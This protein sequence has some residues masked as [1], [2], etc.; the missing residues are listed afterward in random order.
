MARFRFVDEEP[1]TTNEMPKEAPKRQES[2]SK[3]SRF[4]FVDEQPN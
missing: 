3:K 1:V 4:R 2:L